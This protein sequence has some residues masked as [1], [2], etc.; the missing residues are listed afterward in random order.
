MSITTHTRQATYDEIVREMDRRGGVIER[1]EAEI[2]RLKGR[3]TSGGEL[4]RRLALEEAAQIAEDLPKP[5]ENPHGW[6]AQIAAA[7]RAKIEK[8]EA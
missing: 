2:E 7:I 1:L 3:G 4:S 5:G 6:P 8:E